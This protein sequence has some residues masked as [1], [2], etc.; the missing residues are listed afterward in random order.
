M[1]VNLHAKCITVDK[2][3]TKGYEAMF[4]RTNVRRS[5]SDCM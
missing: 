4:V 1:S 3:L 5:G 2:N